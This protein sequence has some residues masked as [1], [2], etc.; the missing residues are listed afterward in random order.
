MS[1]YEIQHLLGKGGMGAV[2]LATS[3]LAAELV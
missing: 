2:Y 1:L 3:I